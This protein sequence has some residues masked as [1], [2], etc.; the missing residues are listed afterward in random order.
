MKGDKGDPGQSISA[1]SLQQIPV[2]MTVNVSQTAI[3]KCTADGNPRPKVTWSKLN[4]SLPV[5]RQVLDSSGALIVKDVR[6]GDDGVYSCRAE[7][8]LGQVSAS[9]KLTVQFPPHLSLSSNRLMA[10][11][12]QNVSIAC[13]VTG[14]PFP[15]ITWSKSVGRL[16]EDRNEVINGTLKIY[17]VSRNEGGIYICKAENILGS[18]TDGALLMIFSP[19]KFQVRPP[20]EVTA[21]AFG[22]S[23]YL[24][25]V[26]ESDLRTT[27]TW[28]KDDKSSLPVESNV[29]QNGTLLIRNFKKSHEGS[30]TCR[31]TN[32][33]TKI[34][35][36]VKTN[37]PATATSCSVIG[38]HV[39]SASGNYVID[40]DGAGG[41]APFPVY[42]DMS[43][44]NGVG[45]TV[46]SHDSESRTHVNGNGYSG[47]G[48]YSRDIHYRRA[49]FSQPASLTR[50]SSHCEEFIKYECW[51]SRLLRNGMAWWVSRDS[52]KMTYW[53]GA[54]LVPSAT[55]LKMSLTSSSGR[56]QKFE[57]FH[58]LTK[59][60]CAAEMK[61]TN[62]Y[63]FHFT[64]GPGTFAQLTQAR[65]TKKQMVTFPDRSEGIV[66]VST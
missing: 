27:I 19:L 29:L 5:G 40:L 7:N 48:S 62:L 65:F 21:S 18:V 23:V 66:K 53:G 26:A 8:L 39:S 50:V 49:S 24:P 32:A 57:V 64:S 56:T 55:R 36:K 11:E 28:T 31:A 13:T 37:S 20:L 16:P 3:L 12:N 52:S 51:D 58:W 59:N 54:I 15:H 33:L 60:E 6:P 63:A 34:E 35:A 38:K 1:P 25:C 47:R 44:K 43:D 41:L 17:S 46:I 9:A 61:I 22:S 45:V 4:S 2:G 14:R 42:C 10:E 30:Y